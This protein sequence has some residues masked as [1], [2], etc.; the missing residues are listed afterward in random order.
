MGGL[1]GGAEIQTKF[2]SAIQQ[3]IFVVLPPMGAGKCARWRAED[4]EFLIK[5]WPKGRT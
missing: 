4:N 1:R 2:K 3:K 5:V